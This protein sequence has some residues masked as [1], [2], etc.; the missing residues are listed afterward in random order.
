MLHN[1]IIKKIYF[2][3]LI[4]LIN[5]SLTSAQDIKDIQLP[6]PQTEIGKPVMQA[7]LL[8]SSSRNFDSKPLPLQEISNLLWAAIGINRTESGKRTAPSAKNAQDVDVYVVMQEGIYLYDAKT[9]SLNLITA[10][11]LRQY[12]GTQNFVKTAPVNLIYVS[13]LSKLGNPDSDDTKI[14]SAADC[15]FAAQNVY[16]YC[17]S[18]NLATVV[19]GS[20]D[21]TKLA[22]ILNLKENQK[23]ILA[24]TV[25]YEK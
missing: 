12:A 1:S 8:R 10:G 24:Q 16:L 18:Q 6:Q 13:D 9:H 7:L 14:Y 15:A 22:E 2:T 5:L 4:I 3:A 17:A 23:V 11:D 21:R 25:G 20:I 19:R